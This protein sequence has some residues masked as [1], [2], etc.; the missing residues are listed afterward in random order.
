[1]KQLK[2]RDFI[3]TSTAVS[4]FSIL[5]SGLL[6]NSPNGRICSAHIGTGG[7]GRVDTISLVAHERVQAVGFCDVDS[8]RGQAKSW[9]S[10]HS[11]AKFFQDYREMLATLGDKVDIVSISTPDHTHYPAT[12]AA[13][14]LG[15]HVYTQ[16]PLT[17]KLAEARELATFAADKKLTTQMGIQNQSRAPYRFTRHHIK[18]GIIG[19]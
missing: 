10:E 4:S 17:H 1:M 3:K 16:K 9:L 11:S 19:K 12:M 13:M 15:K 18:S 14:K 5:P 7:K 8:N 6:A 2:R